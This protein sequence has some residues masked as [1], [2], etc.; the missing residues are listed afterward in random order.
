MFEPILTVMAR[1]QPEVFYA[2]PNDFGE[3]RLA[4]SIAPHILDTTPKLVVGSYYQELNW[5]IRKKLENNVQPCGGGFCCECGKGRTKHSGL[6]PQPYEF[7]F[8]LRRIALAD[9][10][11]AFV[12][13]ALN[14]LD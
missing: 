8:I 13:R 14:A 6:I 12:N 7:K 3:L 4:R 9:P 11:L 5:N 1:H 2:F 10:L